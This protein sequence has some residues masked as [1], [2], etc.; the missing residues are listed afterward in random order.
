MAAPM[1]DYVTVQPMIAL[2]SCQSS[3][4]MPNILNQAAQDNCMVKFREI[5]YFRQPYFSSFGHFCVL[6]LY[7]LPEGHTPNSNKK[8]DKPVRSSLPRG[9]S[10]TYQYTS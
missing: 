6:Y 9:C 2:V 8:S 4:D 5:V 1:G 7:L 10:V 3:S